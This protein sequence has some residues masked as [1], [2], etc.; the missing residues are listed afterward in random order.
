MNKATL[1]KPSLLGK[2]KTMYPVIVPCDHFYDGSMHSMLC[3]QRKVSKTDGVVREDS[4]RCLE[5]GKPGGESRTK[6]NKLCP[7]KIHIEVQIPTVKV[8]GIGAFR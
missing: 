8:F 5:L 2:E 4:L 1:R 3:E 7:L 6:E